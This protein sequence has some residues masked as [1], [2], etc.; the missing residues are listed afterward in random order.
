MIKTTNI[1][2]VIST[3]LCMI[4]AAPIAVAAITD[5]APPATDDIRPIRGPITIPEPEPS[6]IPTTAIQIGF[7]LL[8]LIAI[9]AIIIWLK[10][11][12]EARRLPGLQQK[13]IKALDSAQQLITEDQSRDY[14]I[15]VSDIVRSFIE[16][17]FKLPATQ[18]TSEEFISELAKGNTVD[19]GPYS[20]T[21]QHFLNQ[22][23]FGK[24]S[25]DTLNSEEMKNLHQAALQVVQCESQADDPQQRL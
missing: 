5:T 8:G 23:D 25:G 11:R 12:A 17:R 16:K 13:A 4:S 24:F 9:V 1:T 18:R 10:R 20:E 7:G 6:S 2:T 3:M 22:C 14:T 21:I 19:L 15:S